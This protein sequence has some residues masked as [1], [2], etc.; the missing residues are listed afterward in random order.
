LTGAVPQRKALL[1][2]GA[3]PGHLIYVTGS[4]GGAAAELIA[5]EKS[6]ESFANATSATADSPHL[7]PEPRI[8]QGIWLRKHRVAS[9]AM[10]LSDGLSTDLTH[11]C[12]ESHVTAEVHA[13]RLPL[14]PG[15]TLDMALHGGEDYELLFTASPSANVPKMI[16]GVP[17]TLVGQVMPP[18]SSQS[19]AQPKVTLCTAGGREAL[20]PHGW[21]HFAS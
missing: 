20:V 11:L 17:V 7:Y 21:E 19:S 10:D 2:S 12:E 16:A 1:R 4:L 14:G 15:A 8:S 3:R 5:L 6:P 18:P 13:D 9:A